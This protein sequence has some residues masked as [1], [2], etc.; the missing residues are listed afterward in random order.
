[1][2]VRAAYHTH[3]R[4]IVQFP[5]PVANFL[6]LFLIYRLKMLQGMD[7][8]GSMDDQALQERS[9]DKPSVE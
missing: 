9:K 3:F 6:L 8:K 2:L 7:K 4:Y 1:M 5:S